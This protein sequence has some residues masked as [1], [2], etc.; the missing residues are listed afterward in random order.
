MNINTKEYWDVEYTKGTEH[1]LINGKFENKMVHK[2]FDEIDRNEKVYDIGC[3]YAH[4][5]DVIAKL[6]FQCHG[7]DHSEII[8]KE[9]QKVF[10]DIDYRVMDIIHFLKYSRSLDIITAF[11]VFEHFEKPYVFLNAVCKAL[12][13]D[14]KFI[15]SVPHKADSH[16]ADMETH[17][18]KFDYEKLVKILFAK[19]EKVQF[20]NS[21]FSDFRVYCK[22][23][24]VKV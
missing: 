17:Y 22:A 15:F 14:G 24:L 3:G 10:P 4:N 7:V 11:E 21:M 5:T 16:H 1:F 9:N 18:Q 12:K 23:E 19:F 13:P 8:I 20:Y 6:G 2:I